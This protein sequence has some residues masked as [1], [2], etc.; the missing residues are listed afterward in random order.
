MPN[1]PPTMSGGTFS[2]P[3][4]ARAEPRVFSAV[5]SVSPAVRVRRTGTDDTDQMIGM[6]GAGGALSL[7]T[8]LVGTGPRRRARPSPPLRASPPT[9]FARAHRAQR[10]FMKVADV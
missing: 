9:P 2:G 3:D 10:R 4:S 8:N 5:Q 6:F 1:K 7:C